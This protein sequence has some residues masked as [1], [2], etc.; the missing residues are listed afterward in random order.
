LAQKRVLWGYTYLSVT[1]DMFNDLTVIADMIWGNVLIDTVK[2]TITLSYVSK[3][4]LDEIETQITEYMM[5]EKKKY[6]ELSKNS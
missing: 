4:A 1:P 6:Q 5:T 3:R 2:E